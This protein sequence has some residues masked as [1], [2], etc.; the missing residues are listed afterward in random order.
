[1]VTAVSMALAPVLSWFYREPRL[2][3]LRL[4]RRLIE[5]AAQGED[6]CLAGLSV[7]GADDFHGRTT[8][9][10]GRAVTTGKSRL[11]TPWGRYLSDFLKRIARNRTS[12]V[13]N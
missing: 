1:M 6:R 11:V 4:S 2:R 13:L 5:A 10:D 3:D 9:A 7:S 12:P 8:R